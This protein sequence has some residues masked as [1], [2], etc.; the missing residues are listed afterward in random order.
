MASMPAI[1][2]ASRDCGLREL[3]ECRY[4]GQSCAKIDCEYPLKCDD[5]NAGLICNRFVGTATPDRNQIKTCSPDDGTKIG[6]DCS[7]DGD[8][9]SP[10]N[11]RKAAKCL[12]N[13]CAPDLSCVGPG[14]FCTR[15]DQC[16]SENCE[17][18]FEVGLE[19][20]ITQC[21]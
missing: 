6:Q 21:A 15:N 20:P 19:I 12:N 2:L 17:I 3:P 11:G 16:C 10:S 4:E 7:N 1:T 18:K 13:V 9:A 5:C 8:C 14:I